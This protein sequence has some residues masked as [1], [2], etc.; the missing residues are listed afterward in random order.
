[1]YAYIEEDIESELVCVR[2]LNTQ[3][4]VHVIMFRHCRHTDLFVVVAVYRHAVEQ[5]TGRS[6]ASAA[7]AG[8]SATFP[9]GRRLRSQTPICSW[10]SPFIGTQLRSGRDTRVLQLQRQAS[11][12]RS[13]VDDGS[14]P[15]VAG[16]CRLPSLPYV[17]RGFR[18]SSRKKGLSLNVCLNI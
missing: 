4:L 12:R 8:F 3:S 10:S 14:D 11:A 5:R 16:R 6:R 17:S 13:R 7:T 9:C 18:I 15:S 1:M 2:R